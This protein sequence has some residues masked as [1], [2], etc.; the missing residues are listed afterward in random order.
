MSSVSLFQRSPL[1][2]CYVHDIKMQDGTFINVHQ[3]YGWKKATALGE[4][5]LANN[6]LEERDSTKIFKLLKALASRNVPQSTEDFI[7]W[8]FLF[9]CEK[10]DS[11]PQ[12]HDECFHY[13]N[14]LYFEATADTFWGCGLDIKMI[15][16]AKQREDSH[17]KQILG[18]LIGFNILGWVVKVVSLLKSGGS[19]LI[20]PKTL[21]DVSPQCHKGLLLVRKTLDEKGVVSPS[22]KGY[23]LVESRKKKK[24][25]L[26]TIL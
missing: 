24:I 7:Y 10:W 6:I 19:L 3:M 26:H 22:L 12:F 21:K 18:T 9:L 15:G 20:N 2:N 16:Q 25:P 13:M 11:V 1:S 5:F 23:T 17:T 4:R 8:M 14:K